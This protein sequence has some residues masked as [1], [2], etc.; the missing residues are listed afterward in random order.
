MVGVPE[1]VPPPA[2]SIS[3]SGSAPDRS[4]QLYGNVPPVACKVTL[5]GT[6]VF[7]SE[8]V[9]VP[10]ARGAATVSVRV[11]DA[12]APLLSL[13]VIVKEEEPTAEGIPLRTPVKG[14]R[15]IPT[16]SAPPVTPQLKGAVPPV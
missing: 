15:F 1:T 9:P 10:M 8:M 4:D 7:M 11:W 3:P 5:T 6:L 13:T 16:G 2:F 12:V 14:S